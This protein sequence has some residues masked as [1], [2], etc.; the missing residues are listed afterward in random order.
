MASTSSQIS[1]YRPAVLAL[2]GAAAACG[3]Y[4]LCTAISNQPANGGLR[5]SNAV[6]TRR[7]RTSPQFTVT[8]RD[9]DPDAILGKIVCIRGSTTFECDVAKSATPPTVLVAA[10]FPEVPAE[11]YSQVILA[12]KAV[13]CVLNACG[14]WAVG[15]YVLTGNPCDWH[16]PQPGMSSINVFFDYTCPYG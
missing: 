11:Q 8:Y 12:T 5:R 13:E 10:Y 15:R 2:T 6:H 16:A 9:P 14:Q 1:R 7:S 3:I 4:A